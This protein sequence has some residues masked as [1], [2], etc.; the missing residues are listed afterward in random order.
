MSQYSQLFQVIKL[1]VFRNNQY[2]IS[3]SLSNPL[4]TRAKQLL[5]RTC[6]I[7]T[8]ECI[9]HEYRKHLSADYYLLDNEKALHHL[10]FEMT[11][12]KPSEIKELSFKDILFVIS[13]QLKLSHMPEEAAKLLL[14]FDLP[15]GR[16][17][18]DDLSD[19]DWYPIENSVFLC[20]E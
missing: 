1:R 4:D 11:K 10:V 13:S 14:S 5:Y 16:F 9:L 2:P 20:N 8:L 19:E 3:K 6:Q 17:P 15:E 12:W 7:F 18:V